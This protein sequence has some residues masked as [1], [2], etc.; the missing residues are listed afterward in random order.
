MDRNYIIGVRLRELPAEDSYLRALP[1]VRHL[2]SVDSLSFSKPV[3]FFV[4]ENGTGKSTLLEA[5]A[6]ASGFNPEGGSRDYSF[7]TRDSHSELHQFITT[8]KTVSPRDGYFLRAESFYNAA[9]YLDEIEK[10]N[11][12]G[13]FSSYGGVPL[14]NHSHGESFFIPCG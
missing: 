7:S 1:F 2:A 14:H 8:L 13:P 10:Y 6:V 11:R 4:G 3:T 9:T 12:N 5:L